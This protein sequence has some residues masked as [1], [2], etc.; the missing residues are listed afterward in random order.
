MA[1]TVVALLVAALCTP[2][3]CCIAG[4]SIGG[5]QGGHVAGVES[6]QAVVVGVVEV[7]FAS[8]IQCIGY[9]L[10]RRESTI[11]VADALDVEVYC[12]LGTYGEEVVVAW[13]R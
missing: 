4:V 11:A 5:C 8:I 13:Q 10:D 9:A 1:Q 7:V 6:Q 2:G 12:A 3:V